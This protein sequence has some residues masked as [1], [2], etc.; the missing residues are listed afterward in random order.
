VLRREH[1]P[2]AQIK[3]NETNNLARVSNRK[4]ERRNSERIRL[5]EIS[6]RR[7]IFIASGNNINIAPLGT[8]E[9]INWT[10][11]CDMKLNGCHIKR[12]MFFGAAVFFLSLDSS[13]ELI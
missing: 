11:L 6:S 9:L 12:Y 7:V 5:K 1:T 4:S 10:A 3:L 8:G 2:R 13:D